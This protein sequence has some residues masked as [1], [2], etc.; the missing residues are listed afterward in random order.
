MKFNI[1]FASLS[2]KLN[3]IYINDTESRAINATMNLW[4]CLVSCVCYL[5]LD[6]R[7]WVVITKST[8]LLRIRERQCVT[9]LIR[10]MIFTLLFVNIYSQIPNLNR[11]HIIFTNTVS[12]KNNLFIQYTK[13]PIVTLYVHFS[14]T[15]L[16]VYV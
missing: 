10:N 14:I 1:L 8:W 11:I 7:N 5:I 16:Q 12:Y 3:V 15:I 2:I 9:L 4:M 6:R 13:I